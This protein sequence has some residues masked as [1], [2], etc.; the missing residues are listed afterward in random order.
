MA[1]FFGEERPEFYAPFA[2][3]FMAD[4]DAALVQQFLDVSRAEGKSVIQPDGLLDDGH[5]ET[6]AVG[7]RVGHGGSGYPNPIKATHPM[8]AA[9]SQPPLRIFS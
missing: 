6:V 9:T 2:N 7:L 5:G 4:H 8:V 1:Q 3:G